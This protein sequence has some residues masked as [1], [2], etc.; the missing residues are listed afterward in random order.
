MHEA[1]HNEN[2]CASKV[3]FP[4]SFDHVTG[5][6]LRSS[7]IWGGL[8]HRNRIPPSPVSNQFQNHTAY[9]WKHSYTA[10]L[11]IPTTTLTKSR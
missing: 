8:P 3:I 10:E 9:C 7:E 1:C 5:Y 6:I 2:P 4:M 11:R